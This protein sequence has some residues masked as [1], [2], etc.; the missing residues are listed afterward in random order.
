[1][2]DKKDPNVVGIEDGFN[3]FQGLTSQNLEDAM[4][5]LQMPKEKDAVPEVVDEMTRQ[6]EW[7]AG[8]EEKYTPTQLQASVF[9]AERQYFTKY[10]E[11]LKKLQ[12][13]IARHESGR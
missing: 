5:A 7:F 6:M 8:L 3:P 13:M 12:E 10:P 2:H 9:H 4:Y 1:M 11:R